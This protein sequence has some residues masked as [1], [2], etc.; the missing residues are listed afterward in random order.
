MSLITP[1]TTER[2]VPDWFRRRLKEIDP[3]LKVYFNPIK[4]RWIIDRCTRDDANLHDDHTYC[5]S[6]NVMVVQD[7]DKYMPLCDVVLDK[8]KASDVWAQFGN[9]QNFERYLQ[10]LD[11]ANQEKLRKDRRENTIHV[12]K[13]N[14]VTL[15]K[16]QS[17]LDT[18]TGYELDK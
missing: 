18:V 15:N 12:T 4:Q 16:A 6:T 9:A 8:I 1:S 13:D 11:D 2:I 10:K 14:R 7:D 3:A 5:M 17:L